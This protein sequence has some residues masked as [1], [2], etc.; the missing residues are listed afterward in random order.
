MIGSRVRGKGGAG[1]RGEVEGHRTSIYYY[2][3]GLYCATTTAATTAGGAV[4]YYR[5]DTVLSHSDTVEEPLENA[6][7]DS[8]GVRT[9]TS[10]KHNQ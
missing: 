10:Y 2:Y 7:V 5:Y 3:T 6:T 8:D 1:R 9:P 4:Q